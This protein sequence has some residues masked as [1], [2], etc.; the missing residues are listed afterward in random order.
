VPG[1][2]PAAADVCAGQTPPPTPAPSGERSRTAAIKTPIR[3]LVDLG[4]VSAVNMP[5]PPYNTL[6]YACK[7]QSSVA[8]IVVNDTWQH[9][10]PA[11]GAAIDT[12]TIDAA[13]DEIAAYNAK[14]GRSLGV[15][16]RVW[17]GID[18]PQWAKSIGGAPIQ[19]C[20]Q[21]A[22]PASPVRAAPAPTSCPSV[23]IRTVGR[24]WSDPYELAWRKFEM[25]LAR[26]YDADP[27]VN[28]VS[29]SSCS[30]LTS[31]PF[32]QPED[33]FSKKHLIA[34]RYTDAK[35]R[36]CLLHAVELDFVPYWHQT[37][38][39]FSFN[40]FRE[41]VPSPP[42][43]NLAF[44]KAAIRECRTV[45]GSRCVL[46]NET[47]GKFTPPPSPD[48]SQTPGLAADYFAMWN[49]MKQQGGSITFQTAAPPNLL[50]AW[51]G[52]LAGWNS[53]VSL[54]KGFGA[55]SLE[56]FPPERA[57]VPC[58]DA[59]VRFWVSGYTCFYPKI[60]S[61]WSKQIP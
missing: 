27:R 17:A 56:L 23:A 18:A 43:T 44:T 29:L 48:P 49:F 35:Y 51:H 50:A 2:A 1:N 52:N 57:G 31:E 61:G 20:D 5:E 39:D 6:Y 9:M 25:K 15:R 16:L 60:M 32:V 30:S 33:P 10:Q 7:R 28:E 40:P 24:F 13:L 46:L 14:S 37:Q 26:A 47:M 22:V 55:S 41:I 19:I 11:E 8:G 58:H 54:A 12:S 45:A 36:A 53:A 21:N 3:G 59:P 4:Q 38:V 42:Q 34:A